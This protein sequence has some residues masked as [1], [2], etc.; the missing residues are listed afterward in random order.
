MQKK[1]RNGRASTEHLL[2]TRSR[3]CAVSISKDFAHA[4]RAY[5]KGQRPLI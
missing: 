5:F 4:G 1:R 3:I 2:R